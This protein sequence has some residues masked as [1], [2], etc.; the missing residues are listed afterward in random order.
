MTKTIAK[1]DS[2]TDLTG[3]KFVEQLERIVYGKEK[4]TGI[5]KAKVLF[6]NMPKLAKAL[7]LSRGAL[8]WWKHL[9]IDTATYDKKQVC[10]NGKD[11]DEPWAYQLQLF[12]VACHDGTPYELGI[13]VKSELSVYGSDNY[14]LHLRELYKRE[15][16]KEDVFVLAF[17]DNVASE[18]GYM[19]WDKLADLFLIKLADFCLA[20]PLKR[21]E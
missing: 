11:V 10:Y 4:Y 6:A 13:A 12:S 8:S 5:E 20:H 1:I 7:H 2:W 3:G 15:Q 19:N 16:V 21:Y 18:P 17:Y 14:H 9:Y